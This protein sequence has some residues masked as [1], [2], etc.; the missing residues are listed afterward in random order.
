[1]LASL[2]GFSSAK[3]YSQSTYKMVRGIVETHLSKPKYEKRSVL[4]LSRLSIKQESRVSFISKKLVQK[5]ENFKRSVGNGKGNFAVHV[6]VS[7]IFHIK[8]EGWGDLNLF[9][10]PKRDMSEKIGN[11]WM[12]RSIKSRIIKYHINSK[13]VLN[14]S[15]RC[16]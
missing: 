12:K 16:M 1:M 14:C 9:Q 15:P 5:L 3:F 4:L 6:F 13:Y 2:S 8:Q 7:A 10:L 11:H